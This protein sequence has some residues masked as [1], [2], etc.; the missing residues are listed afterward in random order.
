METCGSELLNLLKA[1]F[2]G[3]KMSMWYNIF[4]IY[5]FTYNNYGFGALEWH[6]KLSSHFTTCWG[7]GAKDSIDGYTYK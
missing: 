3:S 5:L 1:I 2:L 6:S 4:K 7:F